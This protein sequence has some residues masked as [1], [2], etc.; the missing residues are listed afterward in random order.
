MPS[1]DL[2]ITQEAYEKLLAHK[3][4]DETISQVVERLIEADRS[5]MDSAGAFPGL[6]EAFES[7]RDEYAE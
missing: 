7:A 2:T 3:R 1:K 5:P 6:G 4:D